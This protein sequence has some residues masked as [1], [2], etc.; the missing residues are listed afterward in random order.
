MPIGSTLALIASLATIAGTGTTV[1]LELANQP[2]SPKPPSTTPTAQTP[3]DQSAIQQQQKALIS[4]QAPNVLSQTSGLTNPDYVAQISKLL[5]G[6]AGQSGS[7][8]AAQQAIAQA[9]GLPPNLLGGGGSAT[10]KSFTPAGTGGSTS[11]SN[12]STQ[13]VALTDFVSQYF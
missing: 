11:G 5:S 10:T 9:F 8:G 7:S 3:A 1:G 6:T 12:A 13:P 4:Q 2:G